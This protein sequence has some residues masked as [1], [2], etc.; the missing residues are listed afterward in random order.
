[1]I[2]NGYFVEGMGHEPGEETMLQPQS[3]KPVVFDE[4]FITGL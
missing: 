3:H 1:M 4:F 2:G